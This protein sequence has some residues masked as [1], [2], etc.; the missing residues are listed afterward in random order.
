MAL[1][2]RKN[3]K[4]ESKK[5]EFKPFSRKQLK[6][7]N[8]WRKG[9]KYEN[10]DIVI[11][12]GAIR[13]GKTIS[14]LC[15]FLQFTQSKFDGE[16]FIIAGK[17]IGSLKKNVIEPMKQILNAWGWKFDYNRSENYLI[18]GNNTYYMYD[19]NNEASQDKLQ[20]LTAAGAL[21]D[22]VALFPQNFIDQMIGRCS[23]DGAK[24]FMNCNP[25]GPYHYIKTEFIDK[26]KE[27]LICY[28]HFTMDD[29]LSLSEKVKERFRRMFSGVFYKR[30]ILGLWC[31]A[32]GVIYDMF[33]EAKHKVKNI[34]R[35]YTEHYV[36]IDYGTQNATAFILWGKCKGIWYAIK[37]YYYS[38]RDTGRQKTDNQYYDDLVEFLGDTIPKAIIIDPSA[39]SFITLIKENKKYKVKK[40]KNDVMEGIRN[41][42]T[43]LNNTMI[44]F[45]DCCINTFKEFFSYVWD[46]KAIA[47]GEDK[48]VKVK[49]HALDAVRYFVNT[50]LFKGIETKYNDEIYNKGIGLKKAIP[51]KKGGV[52]F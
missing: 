10:H 34:F 47:R 48:P 36:S 14:M 44:M 19:A 8:W 37:E 7:L 6:L 2:R 50:I 38:G 33:D 20:G 22:E 51:K 40:A 21:A 17:T 5:F 41:V 15:S 16:T 3:K 4:R 52:V 1:L 39:A 32:E 23:V 13:S 46:E 26:A 31:Q 18:I 29:N 42:G 25:A 9:S 35:D 12:D 11:A 27:K 28:L 45:N 30:Y 24:I 43:A 49:D